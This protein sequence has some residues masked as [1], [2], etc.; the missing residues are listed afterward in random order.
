MIIGLSGSHRTGKSTLAKKFAEKYKGLALETSVGKVFGEL[1]L[2]PALPMNVDVRLT[3]QNIILN[4]MEETLEKA[5]L[6]RTMVVLDR[7]PI[8]MIAYTL[9]E[10]D[11]RHKLNERQTER[12]A[13]YIER[14]YQVANKYFSVIIVIQPGIPIVE[15]KLKASCCPG[16]I[17]KIALLVNGAVSSKSLAVPDFFLAKSCISIEERIS[18]M[19]HA[20]KKVI[21]FAEGQREGY[22]NQGGVLH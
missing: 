7:T 5:R 6:V 12:L 11:G 16:V 18:A 1:G 8:D 3:V 14:C 22:V 15:E 4:E 21:D 10:F 2:D 13:Q 9:A 19:E 17:E 20:L